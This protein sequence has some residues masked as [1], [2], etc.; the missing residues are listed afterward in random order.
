MGSET[1]GG[2]GAHPVQ[3]GGGRGANPW[4]WGHVSAREPTPQGDRDRGVN[5]RVR[6]HVA[7]WEPASWGDVALDQWVDIDPVK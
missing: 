6:G 4:V 3:G 5:P 2:T 1:R 7:A